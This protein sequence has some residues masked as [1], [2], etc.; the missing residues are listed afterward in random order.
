MDKKTQTGIAAIFF[1]V[2]KPLYSMVP[3]LSEEG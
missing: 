3:R 1:V 2:T